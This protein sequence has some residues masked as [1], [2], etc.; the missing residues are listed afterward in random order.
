MEESLFVAI[1]SEYKTN[2]KKFGI[3]CMA[4]SQQCKKL[5]IAN[6]VSQMLDF[7]KQNS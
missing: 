5:D 1:C 4:F 2:Q 3:K 7:G 6:E